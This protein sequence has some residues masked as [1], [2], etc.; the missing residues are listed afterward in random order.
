MS[1]RLLI[2]GGTVLSM[3]RSV[4][5]L[6]TGDVL[7]EEGRITEVG[8]NL[9][10]R[11][12]DVVD[13]TDTI[14]MPGF[15][16][17]HRH[18]WHA[19]LR[20][21]G[22]SGAMTPSSVGPHIEPDHVY[23]ATLAGLLGAAEAGITT[24]VDW[25]DV[26]SEAAHTESALQAH[27]DAGLRTVFVS[28]E[29]APDGSRRTTAPPAPSSSDVT[30]AFGAIAPRPDAVGAA[31]ARWQEARAARLRIHCHAGA[32]P[33]SDGTVAAMGDAGLPGPDVTLVH[34]TNL[35]DRDLDAIS[36]AKAG[37]SIAPA[38]EMAGGLGAP[39]LQGLID[40]GIRPGLGIGSETEAPGDVFAQ[41]R[42]AN[43][44]Q[45]ATLF[46]L[47][48]AGKGGV[49]NL[50]S[51]RDVIR[52]GT[53]DGAAAV[54]F[55]AVTGSLAPGKRGDVI[56]LRTDRPNIAPVNDP[57]GAV[58]WGMDTSNIDWVFVGGRAVVAEGRLG[59][60]VARVRQLVGRAHHEVAAAAGLLAETR[61]ESR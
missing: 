8:T 53:I 47:K 36:S 59:A 17:T 26:G 45:H 29:L 50:L 18:A 54:G 32:E 44:V 14:V 5:N 19:L 25:A 15:V 1:D 2:K 10:A 49:P 11:G 16:D 56:V 21:A 4:G 6:A 38:A 9:R 23:A 31:G 30:I 28:T 42:A 37:V 7:V 51:T 43:S 58:V 48:L 55:D 12:A 41:M 22:A 39:P 27:V 60:D 20:N 34:C 46:D 40:R 52:Y 3:D 57:I 13:A 33:G 61:S 24:L 35:G